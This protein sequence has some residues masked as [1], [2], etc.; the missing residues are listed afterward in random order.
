MSIPDI[1]L[2]DLYRRIRELEEAVRKLQQANTVYG[3]VRSSPVPFPPV[4]TLP[5]HPGPASDWDASDC[6][7]ERAAKSGEPFAGICSCPRHRLQLGRAQNVQGYQ[8]NAAY[9]VSNPTPPRSR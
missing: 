1:V 4:V 6:M 8:P 9:A 2:E 3:P 5:Y 7:Y